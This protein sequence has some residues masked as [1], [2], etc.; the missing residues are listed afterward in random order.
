MRRGRCARY[1][2]KH[3]RNLTPPQSC[4]LGTVR[5][6]CVVKV[7]KAV[8]CPVPRLLLWVPLALRWLLTHTR[9]ALDVRACQRSVTRRTSFIAAR[10]TVHIFGNRVRGSRLAAHRYWYIQYIVVLKTLFFARSKCASVF[11]VFLVQRS[12]WFCTHP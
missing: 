7:Y 11:G 3:T 5:R 9:V 1:F 12:K 8:C 10:V 4:V 2:E 6:W